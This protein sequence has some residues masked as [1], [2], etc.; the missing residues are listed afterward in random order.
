MIVKLNRAIVALGLSVMFM[1]SVASAEI[2]KED[3]MAF[4]GEN[5]SYT[6]EE[7]I[8]RALEN[9]P[10]I[11][12]YKLELEKI[13]KEYKKNKRDLKDLEKAKDNTVH[14]SAEDRRYFR[15]SYQGDLNSLVIPAMSNVFSYENSQRNLAVIE[16]KTKNDIEAN[17][18]KLQQAIQLEG[19]NKTNKEIV[20]DI[21][22]KTNQKLELGLVAKQ[23]VIQS[24]LA[25]L[26]AEN[27][28][29]NSINNVARAR[30]NFN[31][32]LGNDVMNNISPTG[33][34]TF[35]VKE[36]ED[37]EEAIKSALESRNELFALKFSYEL[38]KLKEDDY[39]N[40]YSDI[41]TK[42]L[43]QKIVTEKAYNNVI[44]TEKMIEMEIRSNYLEVLQKE[45]EVVAGQKQV[46]LAE[47]G[48][49]LSTLSYDV[50]MTVLSDLQKSQNTLLQAKLGLSKNI[51]DYNIAH[52]KYKTSIG[53]GSSVMN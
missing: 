8:N 50:G 24:E 16:S 21:Y 1:T 45:K 15:L 35:E 19:I 9:N 6:L 26:Q 29:A 3:P 14:M 2:T 48:L 47:E 25:L 38:E 30:M 43:M 20:K 11:K 4:I 42:Y 44:N 32:S 22:D 51:L 34:L 5:Q 13:G 31:I 53:V 40:S 28:Y 33:D 49:K 10:D 52:A 36:L 23:D 27:D 18:Y 17:Y 7:S 39:L 46:Q 41:S 12:Q 37:I